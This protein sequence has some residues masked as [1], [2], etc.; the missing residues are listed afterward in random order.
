MRNLFKN[1]PLL[2]ALIAVLL[3]ALLAV[4]TSG[5]RTLSFVESTVG[6]VLQPVQG[7]ASRAS[8]AII[9]F[10]ENVF[11]TTEADLENQQ[12]KVYVSQLEQSL[13]EMDSLRAENERLKSLLA[14]ANSTPDL[15]YVSGTIIGRSRVFGLTPSRSMSAAARA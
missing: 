14:F 1:K 6:T 12:L 8:D 2:I 4:L 10:V 5:D 9:D 15:T 3:L 13:N 7:F 11:N